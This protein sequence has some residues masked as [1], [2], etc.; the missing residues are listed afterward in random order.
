MIHKQGETRGREGINHRMKVMVNMLGETN[1]ERR[2]MAREVEVCSMTYFLH[3]KWNI[4][5][6]GFLVNICG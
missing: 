2:T 4:A 6:R 5:Q 3:L 1:E